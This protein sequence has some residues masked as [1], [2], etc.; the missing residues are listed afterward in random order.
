MRELEF[1]PEWY[2]Q[3][4]RK[5]QMVGFQGWLLLLVIVG[6]G[7]WTGLAHRN[8]RAAQST[9]DSLK[10]QLDQTYAEQR[11]LAEQLSLRQEL[12]AREKIIA[13][14]GFPVEM[15][16]LLQ[17]LDSIMPKE[18]SLLEFRCQ[19]TEEPLSPGAAKTVA[20]GIDPSRQTER[21]LKVWLV[22]VAPSDL[23]LASFLAG[24]TNVLF[25]DGVTV[26]YA[27]DKVEAGHL[28]REFEVMFSINLTQSPG[29]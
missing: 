20:A 17:T 13:S 10:G 28:M 5:R 22:G 1:L 18:M 9:L 7:M 4:R 11:L 15:T 25:F 23:D 26:N 19:T 21:R 2:H 16:R 27:R 12:E 6:L 29:S 14:L 24:L 8:V 3:T